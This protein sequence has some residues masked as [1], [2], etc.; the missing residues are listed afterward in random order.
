MHSEASIDFRDDYSQ[1]SGT[2]LEGL[3]EQEN[4]PLNYHSLDSDKL[5]S[6][7][8][9]LQRER[10]RDQQVIREQNEKFRHSQAKLQ[11]IENCLQ[12]L[13]EENEQLRSQTERPHDS[14]ELHT[15]QV[16]L[17]SLE[18]SSQLIRQENEQLRAQLEQRDVLLSNLNYVASQEQIRAYEEHLE[19]ISH[20][21][22]HERQARRAL[23]DEIHERQ[24][25]AEEEAARLQEAID[26]RE[27]ELTSLRSQLARL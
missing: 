22:A 11:A 8:L 19:R 9:L 6:Q 20:E 24:G 25:Q 13:R 18:S 23:Q 14:R 17:S 26:R 1:L 27:D 10:E 21:L 15:L 4:R 7:V 16:K 3:Q 5:G 2:L 12:E